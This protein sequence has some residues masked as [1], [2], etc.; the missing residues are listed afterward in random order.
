M[1]WPRVRFGL[2]RQ[3]LEWPKVADRSGSRTRGRRCR[4][5]GSSPSATED[6]PCRGADL[7][8]IYHDVTRGGSLGREKSQLR[9]RLLVSF[10]CSAFNSPRVASECESNLMY[11]SPP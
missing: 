10:P 7:L 9:C 8:L 6:P 11:E 1:E 2:R 4:V 5:T 3:T